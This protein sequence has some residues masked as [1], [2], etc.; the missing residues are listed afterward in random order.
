MILFRKHAYRYTQ[1]LPHGDKLRLALM[2]CAT[3]E[4]FERL[5]GEFARRL[6]KDD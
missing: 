4:E 1:G 6:Q 5:V 3:R 2:F